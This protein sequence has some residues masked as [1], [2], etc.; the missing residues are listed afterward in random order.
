MLI[1]RFLTTF[2]VIVVNFYF[3]SFAFGVAAGTYTLEYG[4][5][6]VTNAFLV[7]LVAFALA[8]GYQA[9]RRAVPWYS[10]GEMVICSCSKSNLLQ[11]RNSFSISR[12]PLF[13]LVLVTLA[14]PGNLLDGLS[15]G[16]VFTLPCLLTLSVLYSS[17]Y[18]GT[19]RLHSYPILASILFA[20]GLLLAAALSGLMNATETYAAQVL[21][22]IAGLWIMAGLV[23]RRFYNPATST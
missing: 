6:P 15:E 8:V 20:A 18:L 11:Q 5:I 1:K 12:I 22:I 9:A 19:A 21:Y 14:L 23:Y 17:L 7:P 16:A 10:P 13:L 2:F 3:L 4:P